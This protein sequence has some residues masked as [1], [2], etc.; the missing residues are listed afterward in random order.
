M[1]KLGKVKDIEDLAKRRKE[2][3]Q[4]YQYT[5]AICSETGCKASGCS[6]V[7]SFLQ[8]ELKSRGLCNEIRVLATGCHGFCEQGPLVVISP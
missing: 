7:I 4:R 2:K 1:K 8:K 6:A 5:I 3:N